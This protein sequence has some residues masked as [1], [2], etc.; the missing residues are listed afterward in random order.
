MALNRWLCFI[1]LLAASLPLFAQTTI[2]NCGPSATNFNS[3][4]GACGAQ[5]NGGHNAAFFGLLGSSG[6]ALQ[7]NQILLMPLNTTHNASGLVYQLP[8]NIQAFTANWTFIAN[9]W[10]ITF[11]FNNFNNSNFGLSKFVAGAGCEGGWYQ[12]FDGLTGLPIPVLAVDLD[13]QNNLS[14]STFQYSSAQLYQNFQSPCNPDDSQPAWYVTNKISTSPV[15]LNSPATTTGTAAGQSQSVATTYSVSGPT[16]TV[17]A[18][19]SFIAGQTIL[20]SAAA[21]DALNALNNQTFTVLSSGLSSSQYEITETGVTGSGSTTA[22]TADLFNATLTYD[23][24]NL[25]LSLFDVTAGGS[26]PGASCFTQTWSAVNI[27]SM[28]GSNTAY[29]ALHSGTNSANTLPSYVNSFSYIVN[30]PPSNQSISTYTTQSYSG[31]AGVAN[32]TFSPVAGSYTGTQSVSLSSSTGSAYFCYAVGATQPTFLPQTDNLG[33]CTEGTLYSG[34]ISVASSETV[35][36][37]AGLAGNLTTPTPSTLPSNL[38]TAAYTIN[39]SS[40]GSSGSGMVGY[41][42]T[43]H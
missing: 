11:D 14:G 28:L 39:A 2:F 4:S 1:V 7:G 33:G 22:T 31:V 13:S 36:A 24:T 6:I 23:G 35:Y 15:P 26:C 29:V 42:A 21:A 16:M 5:T 30:S 18:S 27:P 32:P 19:N 10:D 12:A 25:K 3:S 41:G 34:P 17:T 43:I 40:S 37:M 9:G 38:M 20:L 8:V